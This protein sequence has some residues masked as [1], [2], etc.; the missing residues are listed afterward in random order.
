MPTICTLEKEKNHLQFA[1]K[2]YAGRTNRDDFTQVDLP[3]S[4]I[5]KGLRYLKEVSQ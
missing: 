4:D 5:S 2:H 1:M 3:K